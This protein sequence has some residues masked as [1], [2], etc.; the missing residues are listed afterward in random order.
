VGHANGRNPLA[1]VIPCHRLSGS[2]GHLRGYAGGIT[3]KQR[4]LQHEGVRL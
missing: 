2:D 1:I 3:L 4:L